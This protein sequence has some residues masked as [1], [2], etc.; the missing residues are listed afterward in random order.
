[1]KQHIHFHFLKLTVQRCL[2]EN[3]EETNEMVIWLSSCDTLRCMALTLV[4]HN[5]SPDFF[6]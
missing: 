2:W 1:M 6:K 5:K 3:N 4:L